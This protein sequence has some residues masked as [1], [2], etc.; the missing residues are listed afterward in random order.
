MSKIKFNEPR[1][2]P[3]CG[4]F[5]LSFEPIDDSDDTVTY[6]A[7]CKECG[8]HYKEGYLITF[9]GVWDDEGL[10]HDIDEDIEE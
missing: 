9:I 4:G 7:V 10:W 1:K 5:D 2:C 6:A 8:R 3:Y